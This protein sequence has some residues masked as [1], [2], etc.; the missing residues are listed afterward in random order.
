MEGLEHHL[1][2]KLRVAE[3][4]NEQFKQ[5]IASY[6]ES[7]RAQGSQHGDAVEKLQERLVELQSDNDELKER[8][9]L[10][11]KAALTGAEEA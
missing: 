5:T 8:V 3:T 6:E 10:S 7:Q 9:R 1:A 11:E 4:E 2:E